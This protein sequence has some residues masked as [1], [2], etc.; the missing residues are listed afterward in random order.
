MKSIYS[1][2][3]YGPAAIITSLIMVISVLQPV[4]V[5]ADSSTDQSTPAT[6][7]AAATTDSGDNSTQP[8]TSNP[9]TTD[10]TGGSSSSANNATA[11]SHN[12]SGP[13]NSSS[14]N[15][16]PTKPTGPAADTYTFNS[17]TGM[18]EN[19][20]YIWNP[21]TGQTIPKYPPNYSYNPATGMW[22]TL[23]WVYNAAAGKYVQNVIATSPTA[24]AGLTDN[25]SSPSPNSNL[26][27]GLTS[28]PNNPSSGS[29]MFNLF[30]NAAISNNL[31]SSAKSGNTSVS[32]N[33]LGGS[34]Q[35]GTASAIA[36][37]LNLLDSTLNL[38]ASNPL[39]F[40]DNI[41]G[42]VFGDI[43]INP[44]QLASSATTTDNNIKVNSLNNG[45]INNNL[46]LKAASGN[47]TVE[48][49]TSAG[50]AVSG[51]AT[52]MAN[53]MNIMNSNITAGQ[54][55][56]GQVNIYGNLNGDILFPPG[57]L[58]GLL[59]SNA[60]QPASQFSSTTAA[61]ATNTQTITNKITT[62]ASSGNASV[63]NNTSAG[64]A[65][66]GNASTN[67]TLLNLTGQQIIGQ[68]AILVFVN[69]LGNWVGMIMNAPTATTAGLIGGSVSS[70]T[71]NPPTGTSTT[72][73]QIN[74]NV[75][76]SASSGN[77][78]VTNNTSAG[79]ATSGNAQAGADILNLTDSQL[80]LTNWFGILFIN[81]LGNW[82]GSFGVN[83][84][85]GNTVAASVLSDPPAGHVYSFIPK[86]L[87]STSSDPPPGDP[88]AVNNQPT[89][90]QYNLTSTNRHIT[91]PVSTI[92][93]D[94]PANGR[95][96]SAVVAFTMLAALIMAAFRLVKQLYVR[97]RNINY[98]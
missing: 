34:A 74:N 21:A 7:S 93:K 67:I 23:Q 54:S 78:S 33:T 70:Q 85:A 94:P 51:T 5:F 39:L 81:V 42:N 59:A 28:Q 95:D 56:I 76:A 89:S 58:N 24:P 91:A 41:I 43:M 60:A 3:I 73:N 14:G 11:G 53:L 66:S 29:S 46:S 17:A 86:S 90:S 31:S 88:L 92:G 62:T 27:P 22:D 75:L 44:A 9:P 32:D 1:K 69:V 12:K 79:N 82:Y 84:A 15:Q 71:I 26:N 97:R 19:A 52:A 96:F 20:Y 35:S 18:W 48:S 87:V 4:I 2:I 80:S 77:A 38:S 37:I 49:N 50:N 13:N 40:V 65:T 55:F 6:T 8:A 83:T 16:G 47:A 61:K 72:N 25:Q 64:N 68:N 63:T 36:T 30:Y 98:F 57:V 10:N 45:T